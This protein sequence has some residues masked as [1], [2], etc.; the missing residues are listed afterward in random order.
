M[1][2]FDRFK[3]K[4][5]KEE[6]KSVPLDDDGSLELN[7]SNF[8]YLDNLIHSG[9]K[10]I[11]LDSD[12][13]LGDGEEEIYSEGIKI[14]VDHI[15]ID[16]NGHT[17]DA[18]EKVRIFEIE[19][20]DVDIFNIT[21]KNGFY[22]GDR[23]DDGG[24]ILNHGVVCFKDC[25]FINNS[26]NY[27]SA[28]NNEMKLCIL[29]CNF[30]GN[31]PNENRFD[32]ELSSD[33]DWCHSVIYSYSSSRFYAENCVFKN[34]FTFGGYTI[35]MRINSH[36]PRFDLV[37]FVNCDF[38]DEEMNVLY[39][40]SE[41]YTYMESCN[42]KEHHKIDVGENITLVNED[43]D[44]LPTELLVGH[45]LSIE[46][47]K[48]SFN[49]YDG[50]VQNRHLKPEECDTTYKKFESLLE[51]ES[52][53]FL[54]KKV[55]KDENILIA[56]SFATFLLL[57]DLFGY[58]TLNGKFSIDYLENNI[59]ISHSDANNITSIL[60]ENFQDFDNIRNYEYALR[61]FF[62]E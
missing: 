38:Q 61:N 25:N 31:I 48:N 28:I 42:F 39:V 6:S 27:G 26:S 45:Y 2:L 23:D 43:L 58:E 16:G 29:D 13:I 40:D 11:I 21:F 12:I 56:R 32:P 10:K 14:D 47:L 44:N 7:K 30:N 34:N 33:P 5:K 8:K 50:N 1:G 59:N 3:K 49:E 62:S 36:Y 41:Y 9:K 35:N 37:K 22:E 18:R 19:S 4:E 24:A 55:I 17:I 15:L 53:S 52:N 20:I 54:L 60:F 46:D 57:I 51:F